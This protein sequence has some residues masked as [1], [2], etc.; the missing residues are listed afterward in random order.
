MGA[1]SPNSG[2]TLGVCKKETSWGKERAQR[3]RDVGAMQSFRWLL[4]SMSSAVTGW[5]GAG[6]P[7]AWMWVG[8]VAGWM[9]KSMLKTW[10]VMEVSTCVK[11]G[12]Q[13]LLLWLGEVLRWGLSGGEG[14]TSGSDLASK[15]GEGLWYAL[16]YG[17][18]ISTWFKLIPVLQSESLAWRQPCWNPSA[19]AL[20]LCNCL[21]WG[22]HVY[23]DLFNMPAAHAG[24]RAS[25][26]PEPAL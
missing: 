10:I 18:G 19:Q 11:F 23:K 3:P 16:S 25:N 4:S 1:V 12:R 14:R 8:F 7:C 13:D 6:D 17:D 5:E 24:C 22:Y 9:G 20:F 21:N 2:W 26:A 15:L